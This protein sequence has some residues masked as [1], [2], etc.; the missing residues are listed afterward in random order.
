MWTFY[1]YCNINLKIYMCVYAKCVQ[2]PKKARRLDHSWLAIIQLGVM[3]TELKS[4]KK[5]SKTNGLSLQFL[6]QCTV[7]CPYKQNN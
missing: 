2:V 4:S 6:N 1:I 7:T 3:G 5:S